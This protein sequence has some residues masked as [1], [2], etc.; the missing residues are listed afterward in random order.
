MKTTADDPVEGFMS[1]D[2][3]AQYKGS[4]QAFEYAGD[5]MDMTIFANTL[6]NKAHQQD[7]YRFLTGALYGKLLGDDY[8]A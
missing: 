5:G 3:I 6:T 1:K 2:H 8:K 7:D 4:I